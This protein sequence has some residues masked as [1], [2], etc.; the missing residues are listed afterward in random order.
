ML[1]LL[2]QKNDL[3]HDEFWGKVIRAKN[4][5]E[6]R[7]IANVRVADEGEIW[8]NPKL[9]SCKIIKTEGKSEVILNDFHAG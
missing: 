1:Y 4:V 2:K 8:E 9:T 7:R 3:H 5:K 6:A